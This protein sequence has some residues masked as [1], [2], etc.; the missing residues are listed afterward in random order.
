MTATRQVQGR[1]SAWI[2]PLAGLNPLQRW[3]AI[4]S[5]IP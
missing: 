2:E 3:R 1:E 5:K 4:S